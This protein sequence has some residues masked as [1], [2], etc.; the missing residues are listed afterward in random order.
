MVI[1]MLCRIA[2][3]LLVLCPL[4]FPQNLIEEPSSASWQTWAPSPTLRI[5]ASAHGGVLSLKAKSA[6]AYGKWLTLVPKIEA[7]RTY[8]FGVEYRA[9]KVGNEQ[10]SIAAMLSWYSDAAGRKMLQRDYADRLQNASEGWKRLERVIDAPA[11]AQSVKVELSLRWAKDGAVTWRRPELHLTER[12]APP[13]ARIVTTRMRP[14]AGA[15]VESNLERMSAIIDKAGAQKPDLILLSETYVNWGVKAPLAETAQPIPGPAT[16]MLALKARQHRSWIAASL[17]EREGEHIYNTAVLLDREGRIAGKYRKTHLPLEEAERG[18]TPGDDYAVVN[19]DFGRVGLMVCWDAWFPEVTRILRLKGAEIVL[20]PIA[21]DGDARHWDVISRARAMDN[22]VYLIS[23][24]TVGKSASR[25]IDPS[26]EVLA[27]TMDG[28]ATAEIDL[29][30]E[31]R[32]RWLSIGPGDGEAKS[33][34]IKERR[35]DT[36][37]SLMQ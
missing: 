33:L 27:E 16:E 23:S 28:I 11:G 8:R 7:G 10:V 32:L 26:G 20:L 34:Y 21:G 24:A 22:G 36:Y 6:E 25:I 35:P 9:S 3:P 17:N 12:H 2:L 37:Q 19:T 29:S 18:V 14:A 1:I 15:T 4:V 31:W 30:R 13:K 5:E